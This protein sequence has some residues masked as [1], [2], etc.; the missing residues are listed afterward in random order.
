M[1]HSHYNRSASAGGA[2]SNSLCFFRIFLLG[3]ERKCAEVQEIGV[4]FGVVKAVATDELIG[5]GEAD[6]IRADFGDAALGL[7]EQYRHTNA[8]RLA[9]LEY[10]QQILQRHAGV[11]N[12][13]DHDHRL[14][15]DAG[16]QVARQLYLAGCMRLASITRDRDEIE[17]N[18]SPDLPG[19]IGKKKYRALQYADKMEGFHWKIPADFLRHFRNPALD[20]RVR[21]QRANAF[22]RLASRLRCVAR[23][24][25]HIVSKEPE[26]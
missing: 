22:E 2:W 23:G 8:P 5:N 3:A 13:F 20:L 24:F 1:R 18:I 12:V 11:Q 26:L 17:R 10:T 14:P 9:L 4:G 21:N 16:V 6:V 7:V 25:S 15:L 19:Q